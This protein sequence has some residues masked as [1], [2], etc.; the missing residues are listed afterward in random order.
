[1]EAST[2]PVREGKHLLKISV[3]TFDKNI[4][5]WQSFWEQFE[6]NVL[7]K[8]KLLDAVKLAYLKDALKAG[9]ALNIIK[10]LV[11]TANNYSEAVS[12][13]RQHYNRPHLIHQAHVHA[14]LNTRR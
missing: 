3:P 6:L 9:Q 7:N 5:Q 11:Q 4:L 14:F 1:M 2:T 13:Y 10:G 12:C 8:A